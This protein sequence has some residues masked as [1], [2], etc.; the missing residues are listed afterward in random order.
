MLI[1]VHAAAAADSEADMN[2]LRQEETRVFFFFFGRKKKPE[3]GEG[4]GRGFSVRRM[5]LTLG[6]ATCLF[7]AAAVNETSVRRGPCCDDNERRSSAVD[8]DKKL[9]KE[10]KIEGVIA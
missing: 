9:Q 5:N 7:A 2:A 4:P 1:P 10:D 8:R 6:L 3:L